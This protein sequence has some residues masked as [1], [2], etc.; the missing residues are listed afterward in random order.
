MDEEDGIYEMYM[1]YGAYMEYREFFRTLV[2]CDELLSDVSLHADYSPCNTKNISLIKP[3]SKGVH[4]FLGH[5][6]N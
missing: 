1:E 3:V 2:D 4:G 5:Y 6:Q